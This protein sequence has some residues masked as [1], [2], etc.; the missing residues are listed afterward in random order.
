[1]LN[2]SPLEQTRIT[3]MTEVALS[4]DD[5]DALNREYEAYIRGLRMAWIEPRRVHSRDV[6]EVMSAVDRAK[7]QAVIQ[8]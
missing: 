1:M 3:D 5:I 2:R 4:Q 6:Y 7:V 8:T